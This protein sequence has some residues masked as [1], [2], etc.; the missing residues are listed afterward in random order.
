[1]ISKNVSFFQEKENLRG[2]KETLL[3]IDCKKCI[4]EENLRG[5][6]KCLNCLFFNLFLNKERKFDSISLVSNDLLISPHQFEP[7]LDYYRKL[8]KIQKLIKKLLNVRSVK[9]SF[10]EFRCNLFLNL[11]MVK[12]IHDFE[13]YDPIFI[14]KT[15]LKVNS[16]FKKNELKNPLCQQCQKYVEDLLEYL[17][18][19]FN[20]LEVI[21]EFKN[22]KKKDKSFYESL[23]AIPFTLSN[24][25]QEYRKLSINENH[26]LLATYKIGNYENI[27]AWIRQL[28][29]ENEKMYSV[30]LT[31]KDKGEE[32]FFN[33][34]I[35]DIVLNVEVS[36][37]ERIMPLDKLIDLYKN[38][39]LELLRSKYRLSGSTLELYGF[40]AALKKLYLFKIFPLLIDD[41]IE[42]IFLDSPNDEIYLNH[43]NFGRCRTKIRFNSKEIERFKTFIRLYSGKRLDYM[44]PS[45]KLVIKNQYFNCRFAIDIEPIQIDSFALDI[46]KLNKNVFTIQDLLKNRTL[47]P[48]IAAFLFFIILRRRNITITG[49]TDTGKTTMINT[50]DLL[51]PKEFRKI[52]VENVTESLKQLDL[53]KHQ[54][55]YRVDSLEDHLLKK[56]SK[57]NIIKT[58]LHRTPD[59]I[60][61]GE[62]LT[63]EEAEAMFHCLAAGLKG[64]QTIHS[65]N[66]ESLMNRFL[67]HFNIN[68]S[69][70]SDLDLLILM[71]KEI[72]KRRIFSI[73]EIKQDKIKGNNYNNVIF[74]YDPFSKNWC[75]LTSLY[76][77]KVLTEIAQDENLSKEKFTAFMEIYVEI[78]KFI[79]KL[80][81][82]DKIRLINFFHKISYYSFISIKSLSK[83]WN[84]WKNKRNLKP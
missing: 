8:K 33:R 63:K 72:N 26:A 82:L 58:L 12:R 44:N 28:P 20:N 30:K 47:D 66:I 43:Q 42:E 83:F 75:L 57:S 17:F 56:Y 65:N 31:F 11:S 48:S 49:E 37:F 1:M 36:E 2:K 7:L 80:D 45:I 38:E 54:L 79:Q 59:I 15:I 84:E 13:Y 68:Q 5:T 62:I 18:Q 22:F 27:Q 60:Y 77:T 32:D 52:Y 10:E 6:N 81:K 9:C 19:I 35:S 64:F 23:L 50:L 21:K 55:K 14:Y 70:L 51:A 74:K 24:K 25:T 76:E 73:S 40:I 67:Y 16:N 29:F 4:I 3:I 39:S 34:I 53:A 41:Q 78:F 71:K 69:C 46:R 61:L